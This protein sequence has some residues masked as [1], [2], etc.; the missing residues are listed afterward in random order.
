MYLCPSANLQVKLLTM[1]SKKSVCQSL[2]DMK[3][4]CT[5]LCLFICQVS[6]A[7]QVFSFD[8][9][10]DWAKLNEVAQSVVVLKNQDDFLPVKQLDVWKIASLSVGALAET[11]FQQTLSLYTPTT[12]FQLSAQSNS[13]AVD[14]VSAMLD[15][16]D[17]VIL[18]LHE[19]ISENEALQVLVA[20]LM[21]NGKNVV[22]TF[23]PTETFMKLDWLDKPRSLIM[24]ANNHVETQT[25]VAQAIF[26][27]VEK[28]GKLSQPVGKI[29]PA[30][31]GL[32]LPNR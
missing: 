22:C 27:G 20:R 21:G 11:P 10:S 6:Q 19:E 13:L 18:S 15:K 30:G 25:Y 16:S 2:N 12:H 5:I 23:L 28:T 14:S 7:Q 26:G 1:H 24:A 4:I 9:S 32:A 8:I 29:Y 31:T 17:W 3:A